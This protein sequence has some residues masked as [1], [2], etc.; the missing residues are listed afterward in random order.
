M[1][2]RKKSIS[3]ATASSACITL[4]V[5]C[6]LAGC[7][8]NQYMLARLQASSAPVPPHRLS[9]EREQQPAKLAMS[10]WVEK[11]LNNEYHVIY[12]QFVS[13]KPGF[14]DA[15]A[16]GARAGQ[17]IEQT[18]GGV[19][20]TGTWSEGEYQLLLWKQDRGANGSPTYIAFV[21]ARDPVPGIDGRRLVGFLELIPSDQLPPVIGLNENLVPGTH[22]NRLIGHFALEKVIKL[23]RNSPM[24]RRA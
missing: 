11:Y 15:A 5:C 12:A 19:P 6:V 18:L 21:I 8:T 23:L 4:L 14:T 20:Q 16:M 17:Y 10:G 22:R 13:V 24:K 9:P 7:Q 1:N 3:L 2:G